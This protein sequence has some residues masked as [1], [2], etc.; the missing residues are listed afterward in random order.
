MPEP[1]LL[2][3]F[4]AVGVSFLGKAVSGL[5]GNDAAALKHL[6]D[7]LA[8]VLSN[9][10]HASLG[11]LL[12][13][14]ADASLDPT[15]G[16]PRN[17][18][19]LQ[20]SRDALR[21]ACSV[22]LL[23]QAGRL[24]PRKPWLPA[25]LDHIRAGKLGTIPL[26]QARADPHRQWLE[27]LQ[28]ALVSD[29]FERWHDQLV[30]NEQE[31]R[32]C[33]RGGQCRL[34]GVLA[35]HFLEWAQLETQKHT[36]PEGF[37]DLVECGWSVKPGAPT[38]TLDQAYC[39][40]VREHL[41]QRPEV[42]RIYVADTLGDLLFAQGGLASATDFSAFE[43]WLAPQLGELMGLAVGLDAQVRA[44]V[45]GQ[46]TLRADMGEIKV[47]LLVLNTEVERGNQAA[48][49]VLNPLRRLERRLD[50]AIAGLSVQRFVIPDPPK[51]G[52][53]LLKAKHRAAGLVARERDLASLWRWI[54][55]EARISARLIVGR[56]GSGKTRLAFEILLQI[57][58][59]LPKWEAG[60]LTGTVL[61]K[62]EAAKQPS[63][64][65]WS[66]P[67]LLVVDYAQPLAA[68]LGE[69]LRALTYRRQQA[70]LPP[71]R[72]LL[73]ERAPGAGLKTC[74]IKKTA[75]V[76][77]RCETSSILRSRSS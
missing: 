77:A 27:A 44:V 19:L 4:A 67:T 73:L 35:K 71:L 9:E 50:F 48:S 76:P 23:E 47:A 46:E 42:F 58:E 75:A 43:E 54:E 57:A 25:M 56:A 3:L 13:R 8:G 22:L 29:R 40:F 52:L 17:H 32:E 60:L 72:L 6:G 15:T 66:A 62:F 37:A 12:A 24:D 10:A 39:L 11:K 18:D 64:W 70:D 34:R 51:D 74:S 5:A 16:L 36:A 41:K 20:A 7:G 28:E 53:E 59:R 45:E 38:I 31:M 14:Y 21:A 63:D 61:R 26:I 65:R 49:E 55:G 68:P 2:P 30:L 33:F 69:L 1:I